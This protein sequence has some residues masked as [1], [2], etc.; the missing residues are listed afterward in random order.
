MRRSFKLGL[1]PFL[2]CLLIFTLVLPASTYALSTPS[3]PT[4]LTATAMSSS[5]INLSWNTVGEASQ[6]YI[7]RS[8]SSSGVYTYLGSSSTTSYTNTGISATTSYYYKVQAINSVGSSDYSWEAWATTFATSSSGTGNSSPIQGSRLAGLDRYET[9]AA[10]AQAGWNTSYYAILASGEN[11]PDALCAAPLSTKYN[12]PILLTSTNQLEEPTKNQL[13]SLK[14]K[15]V[16]MIGGEGVLT[17]KVE[18]AIKALGI[19]VTRIAGQ[20]R[21]ET[22]LK[23]AEVM[24]NFDEA[25][26]ATGEDFPDILSISPIAAQKGM[27]ILLTPRDSL[28]K[29]LKDLL[30]KSV[31]ST[32]VLGDTGVFS[33][34]VVNQL[35][36]PQRL[37][38]SGRYEANIQIIKAFANEL[39]MSTCYIAT[40][41]AF[42]DALSGSALASITKSPVLLV[43]DPLYLETIGFIRDNSSRIKKVTAFGGT[44][45]VSNSLLDSIAPATESGNGALPIPTN[46]VATPLSS[47]QIYLAWDSV[48]NATTYNI[49]R[50]TS[51]SG[52][53]T[54]IATVNTP[55]YTDTYLPSSITYYYKVQAVNP[56]GSGGYSN[57]VQ[58]MTVSDMS[59]LQAPGNLVAT[60]LSTS[61]IY[62]TWYTVPNAT[63]YNVY[64]TTADSGIYTVVASVT[65]PYYS[66]E[67]VSTGTTYY[68]KVQAADSRGTGP[69]SSVVAGT[70]LL[71]SSALAIPTNVV[72]TSLNSSQLLLTWNSVNNATYY[73]V[74]RST[75]YSGTYTNVATVTIP[76][77]TDSSLSPGM[78][79]YYKV[80][81]V[82]STG[83]SA[84]SNIAYA[85]TGS[86]T[87][88][89]STPSNVIA[90][91]LSSNQIYLTWNSVSNAS[92]YYVYR[93]TSSSGTYTAV[94]SV[95]TPYYADKSLLSGTRYYYQIQAGNS[96]TTGSKSSIVYATTSN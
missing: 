37:S 8:N 91:T 42:P 43:N 46:V 76:Y 20:D 36:S 33:N 23:V 66:D 25:V 96:S 21:Y 52:V 30:A 73:N 53:Y 60:P 34:I 45:A 5:Q 10:I 35:P 40:G 44:G 49:Y 71:G 22:S 79:Y 85:I 67:N 6:Y 7:Y 13:L 48:S 94:A 41:G 50:A 55:Y 47:S 70:A 86:S 15:N 65:N 58:A 81:S 1:I 68:Y 9:S 89:L 32:Y 24:G 72:A 31:R 63:T 39:D 83:S 28:S 82:N 74:Y 80:Q 92:Y 88:S 18:Q 93:S 26:I 29:S 14:V 87:S 17:S 54:N 56:T 51:Y 77:Y 38:G 16:I 64:R 90:T 59:V 61:E 27:P 78:T 11:F 12:A 4:G 75:S 69:Y 84:Y 3:A 2:L 62:M 95:T 57:I 19:D